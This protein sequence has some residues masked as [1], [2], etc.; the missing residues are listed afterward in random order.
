MLCVCSLQESLSR[1]IDELQG[2][3]DPF[4]T[5]SIH[6]MPAST[7]EIVD[8]LLPGESQHLWQAQLSDEWLGIPMQIVHAV[9]RVLASFVRSRERL[10][11]ALA[12]EPCPSAEKDLETF[13]S[14]PVRVIHFNLA[15]GTEYS[16]SYLQ[17]HAVLQPDGLKMIPQTKGKRNLLIIR[18]NVIARTIKIGDCEELPMRVLKV[19]RSLDAPPTIACA[20]FDNALSKLKQHY[21]SDDEGNEDD[22]GSESGELKAEHEL[23]DAAGI[24]VAKK[25]SVELALAKATLEEG[26]KYGGYE[27]DSS[28]YAS[29]SE[30]ETF[31][32]PAPCPDAADT[33]LLPG[34][35]VTPAWEKYGL[36]PIKGIKFC[37]RPPHQI[38]QVWYPTQVTYIYMMMMVM[39]TKVANNT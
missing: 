38:Y 39:M 21:N 31:T 37:K 12:T 32:T 8:H 33:G 25:G 19:T 13:L 17:K 3:M 11:H 35:C 1:S 7:R 9:H 34:S 16:V 14:Q 30:D 22:T 6:F 26:M 18:L 24:H 27:S 10:E 23:A 28:E 36:P 20:D 15:S 2:F 5:S 4:S 29:N